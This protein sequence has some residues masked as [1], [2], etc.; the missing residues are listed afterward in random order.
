MNIPVKF[1]S[2]GRFFFFF[3]AGLL[4]VGCA[5]TEQIPVAEPESPLVIPEP[6]AAIPEPP[7]KPTAPEQRIMFDFDSSIVKSGFDQEIQAHIEY[8]RTNPIVNV[9]IEGHCDSNGPAEYNIGLG[10]KR[11]KAVQMMMVDSGI[12][13]ARINV[14]SRGEEYPLDEADNMTAWE[15]NR[16]VE[17][18]YA[19]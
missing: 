18:V 16:R 14:I 15:Q 1:S 11:A 12:S 4:F 7:A 10:D 19:E 6:Q 17:F 9:T 2:L 8:M 5:S 13:T 3:V